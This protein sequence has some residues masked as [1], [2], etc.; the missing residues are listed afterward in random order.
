[1]KLSKALKIKNRLAG[2]VTRL[3]GIIQTHNS[4]E[5]VQ[6]AVYQ[7]EAAYAGLKEVVSK[8][9]LV[10]TEIACANAGKVCSSEE[11]YRKTPYWNI[12][13][14]A[15]LKGIIDTLRSTSAKSGQ[16]SEGGRFN[17]SETTRMVVYVA[18]FKQVDLDHMVQ[19]AEKR[20]DECQNALDAH[21]ATCDVNEVELV[22]EV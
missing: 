7:V 14:M 21:N 18:T 1:M 20:I 8:L 9:I 12:F 4:R 2:E 6:E 11:E 19:N 5:G 16:F 17:L 15:E 10:K 13:E 22:V 3:K